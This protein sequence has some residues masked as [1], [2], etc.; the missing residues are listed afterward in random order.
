M[1]TLKEELKFILTPPAPRDAQEHGGVKDWS[2]YYDKE[3]VDYLATQILLAIQARLPK[4]K[5]VLEYPET[6]GG[7]YEKGFNQALQQITNLLK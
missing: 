6:N 5:E 7:D 3:M 1:T 2:Y 4:E